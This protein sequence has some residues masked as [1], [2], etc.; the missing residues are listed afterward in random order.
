MK[1]T[2]RAH[3]LV[4][5]GGIGGLA[6]ARV[7]S[8]YFNHVTLVERDDFT[9]QKSGH[10]NGYLHILQQKGINVL[11]SL[12]PNLV[13]ELTDAG[14]IPLDP[15]N[16]FML[17]Q[18][19]VHRIR[20]QSDMKFL[21]MSR[22]LLTSR[23][24]SY[25][26]K[27]ENLTFLQGHKVTGF[28][29]SQDGRSITG[30][31]VK[32][33]QTQTNSET[34]ELKADL[35]VDTTGRYSKS[36]QWLE[37]LGFEKPKITTIDIN[38]Y[39]STCIYEINEKLLPK[40][41]QG[42]I[43]LANGDIEGGLMAPIEDKKWGVI[44]WSFKRGLLGSNHKIFLDF[45]QKLPCQD[46]YKVISRAT[47]LTTPKISRIP[48][49]HRYHYELMPR[50]PKGYLMLG[51]AVCSF[52]PVFGH[53]MSM[54]LWE[55]AVLNSLLKDAEH[56]EKT[57]NIEVKYY[58]QI[59]RIIDAPWMLSKLLECSEHGVKQ[60]NNIWEFLANWYVEKAIKATSVDIDIAS[61]FL[62]IIMLYQSPWTLIRP[63]IF[64]KVLW[65]IKPFS[66]PPTSL[67]TVTNE[68]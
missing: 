54:S 23:L 45:A 16:D 8:Q 24:S 3:A 39:Y 48:S 30:I 13:G 41:T 9:P 12:F 62:K 47:P 22:S 4:L 5:G 27:I 40:K 15:A 46:I 2:K 1:N 49:N 19:D 50:V 42:I 35:I 10:K 36:H 52:H 11:D 31:R 7:L 14:G 58:K 28:I 25:V 68:S 65:S 60:P 51:D 17:F 66:T 18:G 59:A 64:A 63:D 29:A 34:L 21:C 6:T 33:K 44:L 43:T 53:G 32:S 57:F 20:F 67:I 38:I 56:K 37:T 61:T 26:H 55:V